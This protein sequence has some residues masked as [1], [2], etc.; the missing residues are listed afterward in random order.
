MGRGT[1]PSCKRKDIAKAKMMPRIL[2]LQALT[3]DN[4]EDRTM[5]RIVDIAGAI[6][7]SRVERNEA[8]Y[9]ENEAGSPDDNNNIRAAGR[10]LHAIGVILLVIV[11]AACLSLIIPKMAGYEG[12]VV[13]SGSMEPNIPVGSIVYS[14]EVDPV[15]LRTGDVIVFIDSTRGT[16][17]ITHRIVEN[18]TYTHTIITK[19]DANEK[20]D[21]SPITYDN[22]IGKVTAHI[23][24]VGFTVAMF[25]TA[26]GKLV[27]ALILLE[28]WLLMEVGRRLSKKDSKNSQSEQS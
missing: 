11:L 9:R 2:E 20:P 18:D 6:D 8:I 21:I 19:G 12:Y 17:P 7:M 27:A 16:T 26:L 5:I 3:A 23:P 24:R 14:K 28:A 25:T 22:V 4:R 13:V 1:L 15:T 10:L